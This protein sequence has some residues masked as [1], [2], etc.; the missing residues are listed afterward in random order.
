MSRRNLSLKLTGCVWF[1]ALVTVL[2]PRGADA[3]VLT[4]ASGQTM[5]PAFEGWELNPD[6]S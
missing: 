6:G 5:Q 4:Y 3:Q 1:L 2:I